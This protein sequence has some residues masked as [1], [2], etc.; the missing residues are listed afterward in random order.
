MFVLLAQVLRKHSGASQG[1]LPPE[2]EVSG[3]TKVPTGKWHLWSGFFPSNKAI[4]LPFP[5]SLA[6]FPPRDFQ[7]IF[8][9]MRNKGLQ[10][11]KKN[12]YD[13]ESCERQHNPASLQ[14]QTFRS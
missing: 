9:L 13:R 4:A 7:A 8:R 2:S 3:H 14:I 12:P 5:H 10:K 1:G 6:E 11:G